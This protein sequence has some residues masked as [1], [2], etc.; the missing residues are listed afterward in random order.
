MRFGVNQKFLPEALMRTPTTSAGCQP[1]GPSA[2]LALQ[3]SSYTQCA[4]VQPRSR[5]SFQLSRASPQTLDS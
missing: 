1:E 3:I 2:F 4:N 5:G